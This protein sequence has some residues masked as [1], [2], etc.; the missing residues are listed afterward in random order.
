[1]PDVVLDPPQVLPLTHQRTA[2]WQ[3]GKP[4]VIGCPEIA[5]DLRIGLL[6]P[7]V[8]DQLNGQGF[9]IRQSRSKAPVAKVGWDDEWKILDHQTIHVNNEFVSCE[10][11]D[12]SLVNALIQNVVVSHHPHRT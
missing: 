5:I 10:H 4:L 2:V 12:T 6:S 1:L 9:F 7:K 11:R 8:A 3:M